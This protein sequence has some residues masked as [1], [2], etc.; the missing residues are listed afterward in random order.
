MCAAPSAHPAR[1][2]QK[3]AG[4]KGSGGLSAGF[5]LKGTHGISALLNT[6]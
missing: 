5:L 2:V 3:E 6:L 4:G 1:G